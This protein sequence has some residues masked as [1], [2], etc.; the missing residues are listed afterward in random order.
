VKRE[1]DY[2]Q[3]LGEFHRE[4]SEAGTLICIV[5][6]ITG[7]GLDYVLYGRLFPELLAARLLL[8]AVTLGVYGLL[9]A[10]NGGRWVW[11]L[12]L[13]WI[14]LPQIMIAWMIWRTE[15]VGSIY[16]VGLHL[17]MYVTGIILPITFWES[18]AFGI[19]TYVLYALACWLHPDGLSDA[20]RFG[21]HSIFLLMSAALSSF[22][23]HFNEKGRLCLF[24]LKREIADKNAA[25]QRT[26]AALAEIKGHLIQQE[27]MAALG[28]LAA[29]L[30]HEVN[31]PVNFSLMALKL[32]IM[33][34]AVQNDP[35]LKDALLDTESGLE[36]VKGIV[37]DLKTFAYQRPEGDS[38][39]IFLFEKALL[40][41]LRLT[42]YE[43]KGIEVQQQLP[44]DTHVR[45]D[46]PSLIGVLINLL[47]NAGLALRAAARHNPWIC[48]RASHEDGRLRVSIRDNGTGIKAEHLDRVF[49][50]FFT[51]RDVGRGL[52]LGLSVSYAIVQRHGSTLTA[53]SELGAWTEFSF[54]LAAAGRP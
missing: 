7:A 23:T 16:F 30:L 32:A 29:G 49:E 17:A 45:G 34:P 31:N 2:E 41:A 19:G 24:I 44:Q 6:V 12:T 28:T 18:L 3:E 40:S 50:P 39:R 42:G 51:T 27:K 15:G 20:A 5:L 37:S 14:S 46:E 33:E 52:G 10:P 38:M 54:D 22:C 1:S 48:V 26:N 11:P 35:A 8:C 21:G 9:R 36:R 47:S 13:F 25:L 4:Y 43:L 53:A